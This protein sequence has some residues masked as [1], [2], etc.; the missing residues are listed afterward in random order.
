MPNT[1]GRPLAPHV[2]TA[3][4]RGQGV[5]VQPKTVGKE[6][7]DRQL[8][9]HVQ[10]AIA[11][12][13]PVQP[14]LA[15]PGR[16]QGAEH[17]RSVLAASVQRKAT[18]TA[19]NSP[20]R[21]RSTMVPRGWRTLQPSAMATGDLGFAD[22]KIPT[23]YGSM[24][25]KAKICGHDVGDAWSRSTTYSEG[26][27]HAEDALVDQVELIELSLRDQKLSKRA[28]TIEV[29]GLTAT[30]CSSTRG[31][32]DKPD[33]VGCAERLIELAKRGWKISI[34]ADHYYQPKGV[35]NAKEKSKLACKDMIK[36]GMKIAV[37]KP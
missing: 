31:T 6:G 21:V 12:S 32:C 24:V 35:A 2:Q 8:A 7:G 27:E 37:A 15:V 23:G 11:R 28:M 10:A 20:R 33:M 36:A 1:P 5:G 14:A 29:T 25:L 4:A 18:P 19:W 3:I 13:E 9:A 30:P 17:L 34:Q 16:F 26:A 22:L